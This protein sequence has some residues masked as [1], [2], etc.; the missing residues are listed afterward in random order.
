[1]VANLSGWIRN[2]DI[3]GMKILLSE[4]QYNKGVVC[5]DTDQGGDSII[6][7]LSAS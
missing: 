7:S 1:L 3:K 2:G 6:R 4:K 5:G